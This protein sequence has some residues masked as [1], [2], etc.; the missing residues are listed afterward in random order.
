[1]DPKV[2]ALIGFGVVPLVCITLETLWPSIPRPSLV[3]RGTGSDAL[4]YVVEAFV[5]RGVA[6]WAI[7]YALLPVMLLYGMTAERFYGGFGLGAAIPFWWQVPIVFVLADFLSYWQH[8]LFH[9]RALWPI[10]AV[11]HS[12]TQLDWLSSGRFHPLNEIGAQL[13]YVPPI[14]ACGFHPYTFLVLAPFTTW[15]VVF[16]HANLGWT[17]G[18]L[19]YVV[20]SPA[21]HRWHHT[22][23]E[24]GRDKNFAGILAI[25]DVLF[26]TYYLPRG[27]VATVF[28]SSDP[29]PDGFLRQLAYP[30]VPLAR[31]ARVVA[32]GA[33][34]AL[35]GCPGTVN[36]PN[37][38]PPSQ[39]LTQPVSF[40]QP[41]PLLHEASGLTFAESYGTF[42]RVTAY[43][44][45]T[46]GL[47][48]GVGYNDR[49]ASCLIAATFY[50]YPTPRM[51][52]VGAAPEVVASTERGWLERGFA[53]STDEVQRHHA[54]MSSPVVGTVTTPA[55][56]TAL[57]GKS[58]TFHQAHDV[59]E[60]RLF[61]YRHQ[62]F[63]KYRF[64]Y[65]EKCQAAATS[66]L[67]ALVREMPWTSAPQ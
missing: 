46:A 43:R 22:A 30:L 32:V 40:N 67:D 63:L 49:E 29:V 34:V 31:A 36:Q 20:T 38:L 3:R 65:P 59:S 44:Y 37:G 26:G 7:Y 60:L 41:G 27:R 5:A 35:S 47:D 53:R 62:W 6:P 39:P 8:R 48:V 25:W 10:H 24:E 51:S 16:L 2:A 11:H 58:L 52:F 4:W 55:A 14:L 33:L 66:K 21:F 1:M 28:G 15:Y 19:R 17:F 64:T 54:A 9:R 50:L 57:P 18:P 56:G 61:V 23:A 42:Q 13:I 45:D 12:S